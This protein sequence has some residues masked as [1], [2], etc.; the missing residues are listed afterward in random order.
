LKRAFSRR[1]KYLHRLQLL[2]SVPSLHLRPITT[3]AQ[4]KQHCRFQLFTIL[5]LIFLGQLS[6]SS[7]PI[8]SS[9]LILVSGINIIIPL[10]SY[11]RS[12]LSLQPC[13]LP[14]LRPCLDGPIALPMLPLPSQYPALL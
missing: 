6:C 11:K 5:H 13:I 4:Y 7:L 9:T 14:H 12:P 8:Q 3:R 10:R 2:R 1:T